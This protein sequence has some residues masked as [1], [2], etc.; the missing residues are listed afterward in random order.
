MS[1]VARLGP[2]IFILLINDLTAD[3]LIHKFFDD[4]TLSEIV[5]KCMQCHV[6]KASK[7]SI[8][9]RTNIN[10]KKTKAMIIGT[11]TNPTRHPLFLS[12]VILSTESLNSNF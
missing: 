7:W 10:Y 1:Q 9:N 12:M 4:I 8:H 2:L 3:S 11:L 6:A 5:S